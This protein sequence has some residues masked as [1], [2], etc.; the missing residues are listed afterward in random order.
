MPK[1]KQ[2]AV[3]LIQLFSKGKKTD[4]HTVTHYTHNLDF[5]Q[6]TLHSFKERNVLLKKATFF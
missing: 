2:N 1:L 5:R 3:F 4:L 6:E